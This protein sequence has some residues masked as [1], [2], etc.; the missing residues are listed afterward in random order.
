LLEAATMDWDNLRYFLEVARAGRLTTA[1]RRLAVDHTTVSRRLQALEKSIGLQLFLREPGGYKLTEAGRNLLPRVEA[2]E[3]AS[4]AIEHSLPSMGDGLSGQVRIGATE[5]YGTVMLAGQLT[6]LSRRY[7]HLNIDLL[8]LPRAVRLSRHEADIVIT[9]ERPERGPFIITRLTDY[10]LRL[11]AS[12][13]YLDEHP[14]IRSREDLAEHR[15]VSYVD[16]LLFS[17]ELLF[18]DGIADPRSVGL[19]STSLLAQQEA[20]AMGAGIAILPAF[21]A[22]ADPRLRLLL[23]EEVSFTRTFW[24]LMPIEFKDLARMRTTWDYLKEMAQQN[25]GRLLGQA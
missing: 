25:Q 17:K 20:V 16:D 4:V 12:P 11:Y 1:A 3:S 5:G 24:M 18:L 8:A 19:R 14:P 9:L 21:S 22:D 23:P 15:F 7:P 13:A 2:M 10:V 6:G